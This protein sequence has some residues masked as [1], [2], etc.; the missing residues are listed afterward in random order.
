MR[1]VAGAARNFIAFLTFLTLPMLPKALTV[2]PAFVM[3]AGAVQVAKLLSVSPLLSVA[4][5]QQEPT[6]SANLWFRLLYVLVTD[7]PQC[8]TSHFKDQ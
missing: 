6:H 4:H 5:G 7:S 8:H 1:F 3:V 2:T